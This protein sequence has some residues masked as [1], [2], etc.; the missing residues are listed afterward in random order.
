MFIATELM[1]PASSPF[2]C[3][4][5][6]PHAAGFMF[7]ATE[8]MRGGDLYTALRRHPETMR[9]ER[10][11][12]KVALDV[13]L[14]LNYLHS[15]V[16]GWGR[17]GAGTGL[18]ACSLKAI[19]GAA[20]LPGSTEHALAVAFSSQPTQAAFF[21]L[22]L[23]TASAHDAP[24]SANVLFSVPCCLHSHPSDPATPSCPQR[25]PMMH[26]DLKSPNVLLSEEGLAKI[27]DVGMV[28]HQLQGLATAQPVMTPLWAAPEVGGCR[29]G[30]GL[31]GR[32][33]DKGQVGRGAGWV[34][35]NVV[36]DFD[37]GG[38]GR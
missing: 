38:R 32:G 34:W 14:G 10:L 2:I 8:L 9:W 4:P 35:S 13:A 33:A 17:L 1:L 21:P 26:R 19:T 5:C 28:K 16:P 29:R 7:I 22:L 30:G 6:L 23:P 15:Q 3:L 37:R 20:C 24:W 25:P 36:L 31:P 27:A 18:S 11:G 12:R